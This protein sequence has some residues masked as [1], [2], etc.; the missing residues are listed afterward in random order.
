MA[1]GIAV[2]VTPIV[3]HDNTFPE[4]GVRPLGD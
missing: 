1:K 2:K 3:K 4:I